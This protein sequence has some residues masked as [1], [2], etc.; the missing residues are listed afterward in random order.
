[1]VVYAALSFLVPLFIG[2]PQLIVGVIVNCAGTPPS[3]I[4]A[5]MEDLIR[6]TATPF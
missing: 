2:H 5:K 6:T 1:M 3:V 4:T